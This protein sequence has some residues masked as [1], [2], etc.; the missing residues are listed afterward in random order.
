MRKEVLLWIYLALLPSFRRQETRVLFAQATVYRRPPKVLL[1][2]V[3]LFL[4]GGSQILF[5]LHCVLLDKTTE[6]INGPFSDML[7]LPALERSYLFLDLL[8]DQR[9]RLIVSRDIVLFL[10]NDPFVVAVLRYA[11]Y[12]AL[13]IGTWNHIV[14]LVVHKKSRNI[15]ST[16]HL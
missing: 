12:K 3:S 1:F 14:V 16:C 7:E 8:K 13:G 5:L 11:F 10:D 15:A 9:Q 2:N 4:L 6:N